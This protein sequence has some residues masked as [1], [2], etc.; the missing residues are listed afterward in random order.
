MTSSTPDGD[1]VVLEVREL[2]THIG[3]RPPLVKAVDG[4][5]FTLHRGRTLAIV[6][7]SGSGKSMTALSITRLLP[8][9]AARV[10]GGTIG[11]DGVDLVAPSDDHTRQVRG[12]RI[13]IMFQDPMTA[14]NPGLRVGRQVMEPL[15]VHRIADRDG[16]RRRAIDLLART[17]LP[18]PQGVF[19][20]Y[21][22]QLSGGMRQRVVLA[23]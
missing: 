1:D 19:E 10:V 2:R 14:L 9:A 16:A 3:D 7:E 22:H 11:F 13:A 6:G 17:H 23:M 18:D 8:T 15:L 21:P 5:S 12:N 20:A 4:V